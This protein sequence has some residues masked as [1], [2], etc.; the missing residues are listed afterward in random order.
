MQKSNADQVNKSLA[1]WIVKRTQ[2]MQADLLNGIAQ[3][4]PVRTGRAQAGWVSTQEVKQ[5]GDV[6]LIRNEVPY[7]G[8]LEFGSDTVA[9]SGMVRRNLQ[10]ISGK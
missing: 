6:G 1:D 2:A 7:I 9:P 10:R 4:T 3:D 5:I 8:W